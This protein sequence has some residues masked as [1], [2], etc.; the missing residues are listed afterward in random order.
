[1]NPAPAPL[2][3][4]GLA[5]AAA[6]YRRREATPE[7]VL[8]SVLDRHAAVNGRIN[9]FAHLD[10]EGALASAA[11]STA[12]WAAGA[13]LG[14][15]DG[16]IVTVKDNITV[17][18]MPC[19]WGSRLYRDF[20]PTVEE[21]AVAR[22]RAA[23]AI[24]LGKTTCSELTT[25]RTNVDTPLFGTTRNPWNPELSP[26]A[27]SGGAAAA[28]AAGLSMGSLGTDGGGSIRRPASHCG[29]L[30]LKPT[31]G[32]VP[33]GNGLPDILNGC[34]V[35]G[36]MARSVADL[37][38]LYDAIAGPDW[39]DPRSW[40]FG[41]ASGSAPPPGRRR[42]L[43]VARIAGQPVDAPVAAA[44]APTRAWLEGTGCSVVAGELP[45]DMDLFFRHWPTIG[46]SGLARAVPE[47]RLAEVSPHLA[48]MARRGLGR[49]APDYAAALAAFAELG[50]Q[51][52]SV[53]EAFDIVATPS[54]AAVAG[55]ADEN[56]PPHERA[57]TSFVNVLGLPAISIPGPPTPAGMP[58]GLQLIGPF[59]AEAML[60]DLAQEIEAQHPWRRLAPEL[61]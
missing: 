48:A 32:R 16:A 40:P 51:M 36:P 53:L 9:A 24:L 12:R 10:R 50:R 58:V 7:A 41:A 18:G 39:R 37:R 26:G 23:G 27:S 15:L 17:A 42:V 1:M 60:L 59:G 61:S 19:T 2:W 5:E 4:M 6:A 49:T 28:L 14:P 22:L 38:L 56:G 33:R 11:A 29:V 21:P 47:D 13:A 30:G 46:E 44:F 52:G 25:G 20:I 43:H 54:T 31:V 55:R 34:E 8:G 45:L 3:T 35:L 57:F